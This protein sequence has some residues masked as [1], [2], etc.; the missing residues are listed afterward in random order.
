VVSSYEL[1]GFVLAVACVPGDANLV[2]AA[3]SQASIFL[4]DRRAPAHVQVCAL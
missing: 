1:G 3:S 4:L 2:W